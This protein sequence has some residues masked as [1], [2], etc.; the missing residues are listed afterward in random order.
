M[1][2]QSIYYTLIPL[3]LVIFEMA[4]LAHLVYANGHSPRFDNNSHSNSQTQ[5]GCQYV[6]G[7]QSSVP[8]G[9]G[10]VTFSWNIPT[11]YLSVANNIDVLLGNASGANY[12]RILYPPGSGRRA[13]SV[14]TYVIPGNYTLQIGIS[15]GAGRWHSIICPVNISTSPP[16][17]PPPPTQPFLRHPHPLPRQLG[18][19]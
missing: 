11:S 3:L 6:S 5:Q 13:G 7:L 4:I 10:N 14:S 9:G 2:R 16:P 19:Q 17:P 8:S 15:T 12:R 1:L 18:A